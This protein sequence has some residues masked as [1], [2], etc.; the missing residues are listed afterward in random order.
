[1]YSY[2]IGS[3]VEKNIN[4]IVLES[5]NIGYEI[6]VSSFTMEKL[7]RSEIYKIYTYFKITDDG[8][9]LYGFFTREERE[10][11]LKLI[12]VNGVG[13]KIALGILSSFNPSMLTNAI[14]SQDI[15][16]LSQAKGVGKK[17]AERIVLELK[18]KFEFDSATNSG[19][20]VQSNLDV[21]S[22]DAI[23]ALKS[24]GLSYNEAYKSVTKVR[25]QAKNIEELISLALKENR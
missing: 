12:N 7:I 21:D 13:S 20:I 9:S 19:T 23:E 25:E 15:K 24:L 6:M 1:M 17:M 8:I 2:I 14:A 11:F 3:V 5:N 10:V 18:D 4:G 16:L 22:R